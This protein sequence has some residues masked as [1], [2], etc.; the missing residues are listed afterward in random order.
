MIDVVSSGKQVVFI[1]IFLANEGGS[2]LVNVERIIREFNELW[3]GPR[4]IYE[5]ILKGDGLEV[6]ITV[7]TVS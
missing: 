3:F 6:A 2:K 7:E 5:T 4:K 1:A